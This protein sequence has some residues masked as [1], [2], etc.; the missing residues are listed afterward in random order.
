MN[1]LPN[2]VI[3]I[4][5]SEPIKAGTLWI[6]LKNSAGTLVSTNKSISG[7]VLTITHASLLTT[8]K[9]TLI[10]HTGSLKDLAGNSLSAYTSNFIVDSTPPKVSSTT[11]TNL[12]TKVSPTAVI[13]IKFSEKIKAST[14]FN[15]I[16]IKN[17][18]T[19]KYVTITKAISDNILYIK[20]SLIE[21]QAL[22]I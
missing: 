22:G 16:T 5:F 9:Y 20:T 17:L 21:H 14:S 2:K 3:K 4:T 18:T 10:L 11:P 13:A 12:K 8:G 19:G 15:N 6:N 7:N 1:V